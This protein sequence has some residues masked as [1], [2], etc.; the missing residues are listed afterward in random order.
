MKSRLW[1]L[2]IGVVRT[3]DGSTE[4]RPGVIYHLDHRQLDGLEQQG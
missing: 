4:S 2:K 1:R 3:A